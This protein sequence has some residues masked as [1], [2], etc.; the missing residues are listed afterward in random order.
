[1]EKEIQTQTSEVKE[2][3]TEEQKADEA[4]AAKQDSEKVA[5]D[6]QPSKEE[7]KTETNS[8][9]L[10]LEEVIKGLD[11]GE[12]LKFQREISAELGQ[13]LFE[14]EIG[15]LF[16]KYKPNLTREQQVKNVADL[17]RSNK[18]TEE[19]AK[20][21]EVDNSLKQELLTTKIKLEL[22]KKGVSEDFIDDATTVALSKIKDESELEKC[23]EI[24]GRYSKLKAILNT[25]PQDTQK[26]ITV[27]EREKDM[28][29]GEKAV[30]FL[31]KL[32]PKGYK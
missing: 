17:I 29:E 8:I 31:K 5:E 20:E 19:T 28:T 13:N 4:V 3:D 6:S 7:P 2:P 23:G 21:P 24:A 32:N 18:K 9:L 27:G 16:K 1:M 30:A 14:G 10:E 15:E 12:V 25:Y 11:P 26:T 22:Y